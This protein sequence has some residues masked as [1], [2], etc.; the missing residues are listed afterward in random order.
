MLRAH[1]TYKTLRDAC[2]SSMRKGHNNLL[3][4]VKSSP[5]NA[6]DTPRLSML[7]ATYRVHPSRGGVFWWCWRFCNIDR[8]CNRHIKAYA[9]VAGCKWGAQATSAKLGETRVNSITA[10]SCKRQSPS[11]RL[12]LS[13]VVGH[14]LLLDTTRP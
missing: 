14:E 13:R 10:Q 8:P 3:C 4:V 6:M 12:I 5:I 1:R 2:V 11:L 9:T 7:K